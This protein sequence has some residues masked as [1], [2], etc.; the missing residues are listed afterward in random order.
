MGCWNGT[1]A[2][3]NLPVHDNDEVYVF[4][5]QQSIKESNYCHPDKFW[6]LLPFFFEGQYND[7]GAAD[8]CHGPLL[9]H[10]ITSIQKHLHE[11][12]EGENTSHDIPVK[13]EGFNIE[14]FF[15]ADHE[16]RLFI[17]DVVWRQPAALK[18]III[19]KPV[20]DRLLREYSVEYYSS[21]IG[22]YKQRRFDDVVQEGKAHFTK[23]LQKLKE[24]AAIPD[25]VERVAAK[26]KLRWLNDELGYNAPFGSTMNYHKYSFVCNPIDLANN[27][28]ETGNQALLDAV[29]Y[30]MSVT[31]WLNTFVENSRGMWCP[32]SGAGS[33]DS[34]TIAQRLK[35]QI[36]LDQGVKIDHRWGEE[37]EEE[38]E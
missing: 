20:L 11:M 2:I 9:E 38:D 12:E 33:Q 4:I 29:V 1:C 31:Y 34:D 13:K 15:E 37:E 3:T 23:K 19:L 27:A 14:T 25:E 18:H 8:G 7:Y 10:I 5:L 22:D 30:Q 21:E 35:A 26:F 32:P 17:D 16:E 36:T 6:K 28:I 24:I